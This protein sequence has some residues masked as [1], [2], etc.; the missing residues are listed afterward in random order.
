M[1]FNKVKSIPK[2][3]I[4]DVDGVLTDGKFY[5]TENGKKLKVF[6]VDDHD[7]LKYINKF[8]LI[9][10]V[11]ADASGYDITRRR[12]IEEM[13][14]P[15]SLVPVK[16]R[17]AWISERFSLRETIYMGDG[18]FDPLVF[19]KVMYSIAPAN[20]IKGTRSKANFV[21]KSKGGE[22][23]VAEACIHIIKK[24]FGVNQKEFYKSI[25][26]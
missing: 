4:L 22:R 8:L 25:N 19:S 23:A 2:N 12:I 24:F 1:R 6:G 18:I 16:E 13:N 15:L 20:A 26:D 3:F 14:F 9:H 5:Y 7:A 17:A 10:I 11:T 21:T